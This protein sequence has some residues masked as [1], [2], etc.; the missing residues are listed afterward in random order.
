MKLVELDPGDLEVDE[1]NLR[2]DLGDLDSLKATIGKVGILQPLLVIATPDGGFRVRIGHRRR[3]AAVQLGLASV[4]CLVAESDD[5]ASRIL[6]MIIENDQRLPL[7]V[8][9]RAEGYAQLALLEWTPAA[10]AEFTGQPAVQVERLLTLHRLP[11]PAQRAADRGDLTLDDVAE[12]EEFADD[13]KTLTAILNRGGVWGIRH[14]LSQ[15]KRK[16]A[17]QAAVAAITEQLRAD[18]VK[19]VKRPKDWPYSSREARADELTDADGIRLDPEQVAARPG[20]AAFV[21]TTI[22]PPR[23]VVVCT[24]PEGWGYTRTRRTSYRSEADRAQQ[25]AQEREAHRRAEALAA[26]TPVRRSFIRQTYGSAKAAKALLPPAVRAVV[27]NPDALDC[28][29]ADPLIRSV[30]RTGIDTA[31]TAGLERLQRLLVARWVAANEA[32]VDDASRQVR[33]RL[34]PATVLAWLD[35]LT[36]DGYVLSDAESGLHTEL[37]AM[38]HDDDPDDEN[39]DE[40]ADDDSDDSDVEADEADKDGERDDDSGHGFEGAAATPIAASDLDDHGGHHSGDDERDPEPDPA[41]RCHDPN[42]DE[43][44]AV[45]DDSSRSRRARRPRAAAAPAMAAGS[46]TTRRRRVRPVV[47]AQDPERTPE[48]TA[49]VATA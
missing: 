27:S 8:S 26:A 35:Q 25:A 37:T 44:A 14:A 33:W 1:A 32:A 23:A 45:A 46:A 39:A 24:D 3:E 9:E 21:D 29:S 48:Q 4:P 7:M 20:F 34:R 28:D 41:D 43:S 36:A 30:A 16:R 12:L 47:T 11:E 42:A 6:G 5:E 22:A 17:E 13:P 18:G 49:V 15:E 38:A 10:I 40:N 2:R 31:A 19:I